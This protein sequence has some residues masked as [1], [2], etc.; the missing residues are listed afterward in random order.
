MSKLTPFQ[1][2]L[3]SNMGQE[4]LDSDNLVTLVR[5][6]V[7]LEEIVVTREEYEKLNKNVA[8][9]RYLDGSEFYWSELDWKN[10]EF[11]DWEEENT[12]YS[13]Y[14]GDITSFT[15]DV[16]SFMNPDP[17][18]RDSGDPLPLLNSDDF[19]DQFNE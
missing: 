9:N 6:K 1:Q 16:V 15:D 4:K 10:A 14:E 5:R 8:S 12:H 19:Y 11:T 2:A 13:A 18:Y 7:V 17:V 3:A